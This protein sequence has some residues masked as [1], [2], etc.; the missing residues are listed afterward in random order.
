[1]LYHSII[2]VGYKKTNYQP[3]IIYKRKA[4]FNKYNKNLITI[5]D[6]KISHRKY[7]N[8]ILKQKFFQTILPSLLSTSKCK[9]SDKI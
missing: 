7:T 6:N 8:N 4:T 2:G 1:M 3:L 9:I 5:K